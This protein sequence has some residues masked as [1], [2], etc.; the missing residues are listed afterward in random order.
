V[1]EEARIVA[2]VIRLRE[3]GAT[4]AGI[5]DMLNERG[6]EGKRGGRWYASTV[7]YLLQRQ[8]A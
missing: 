3:S 6:I 1:K 8:P 4:L 5:A 2:E 7:R